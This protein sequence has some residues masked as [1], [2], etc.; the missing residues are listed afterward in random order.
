[1][2]AGPAERWIAALD[3]ILALD[4]QVVLPGHGPVSGPAEV[5]VLRDYWSMVD[6][7]ARPRFGEG[8][9]AYDAAVEITSSEEF[10]AGPWA[11]WDHLERIVI[12]IHTTYRHLEGAKPGVSPITRIRI[13]DEVARLARRLRP[14]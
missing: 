7:A 6:A 10:R 12:G 2:W 5:Q 13:F 1:M 11:D 9:S 4:P 8:R 3:R 14:A